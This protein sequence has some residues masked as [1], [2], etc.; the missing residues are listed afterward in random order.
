[1]QHHYACSNLEDALASIEA[2]CSQEEAYLI[3]DY[4]SQENPRSIEC[5]T[6]IS[7][8]CYQLVD[9]CKFN[10]ETVAISINYLDRF[11]M[12]DPYTLRKLDMLQL[13][14][15]TCLYIAVKVHE[16]E[17]MSPEMIAKL[18]AGKYTQHEI[19]QME[20]RILRTIQW[21]MNPPTSLS[22]IR[23]FMALIPGLNKCQYDEIYNVAKFQAELAVNSY[24]LVRIRPSTIGFAALVNALECIE[25][26][27]LH[28]QDC[29]LSQIS[30][31]FTAAETTNNINSD[32]F[33]DTQDMLY[34]LV[35]SAYSSSGTLKPRPKPKQRKSKE[36]CIIPHTSSPRT[37]YHNDVLKINY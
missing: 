16:D 26:L 19:T 25:Q 15:M 33:I 18:S 7:E 11:L 9:F 1:M 12:S 3:E 2:M 32:D 10:R 29:F 31:T 13:S 37:V 24:D 36:S 14:A 28:S 35:Q 5:R 8:W 22:F 4:I 30:N 6:R 27:P 21:R 17:A 34:F 23:Y 20:L